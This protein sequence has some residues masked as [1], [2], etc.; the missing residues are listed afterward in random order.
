MLYFWD[1]ICGSYSDNYAVRFKMNRIYKLV[2]ALYSGCWW[3][4]SFEFRWSTTWVI[5]DWTTH[6]GE[7][8][9]AYLSG[10]SNFVL[11]FF[12]AAGQARVRFASSFCISWKTYWGTRVQQIVHPHRNV[13]LASF[14]SGSWTLI[15][16]G[17][18]GL[19]INGTGSETT[20]SV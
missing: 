1:S 19:S 20:I 10:N 12:E 9:D 6:A 4:V 7:K 3:W 13:Q 14:P 18:S 11:V 5:Q 2:V 16:T 17:S 15:R 8:H